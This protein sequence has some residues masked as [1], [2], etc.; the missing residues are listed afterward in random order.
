MTV[1]ITASG[2][3]TARVEWHSDRRGAGL[4]QELEDVTDELA[5]L[6]ASVA[7]EYDATEQR[8]AVLSATI[9]LDDAGT[10]RQAIAAAVS[11]VETAVGQKVTGVEV[12]TTT[13]FDRRAEAPIIPP[14][15]GGVEIAEILG[16]ISRQ[17]V[18][19]LTRRPDFPAPVVRTKAGPLRVRS[20]VEAW[21]SRWERKLGRPS[22]NREPA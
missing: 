15:V 7:V 4:E 6:G 5:A 10:L 11:A 2:G 9:T 14:L 16:G 8:P 12:L 21:A 17:R 20:A 1:T 13:E 18:A 19:E 22:K 3:W